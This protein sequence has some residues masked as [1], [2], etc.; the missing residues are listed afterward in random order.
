VTEQFC[1]TCIY[2][3]KAD[4]ATPMP[5]FKWVI[6]LM[7]G[8]MLVLSGWLARSQAGFETQYKEEVKTANELIKE[9]K[10]ILIELRANQAVIK[11]EIEKLRGLYENPRR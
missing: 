7:L 5:L 11:S 6:G 4:S 8:F 10:E 2:A 1:D 3:R 9:N